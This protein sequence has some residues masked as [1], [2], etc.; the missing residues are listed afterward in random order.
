MSNSLPD[1]P[2]PGIRVPEIIP[3]DGPKVWKELWNLLRANWGMEE[4]EYGMPE[5]TKIPEHP[6][7]V[8]T[9]EEMY[10]DQLG[11]VPPAIMIRNAFACGEPWNHD[12]DG[13]P[14]YACFVNWGGRYFAAY[15]TPK[16]FRATFGNRT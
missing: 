11:A 10:D 15:M 9:T 6:S 7:F 4:D 13:Y 1:K 8:E 14:V 2:F 5:R 12:P 3:T 16:Q